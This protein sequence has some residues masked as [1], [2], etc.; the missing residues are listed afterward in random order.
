MV[1]Q[2]VERRLLMDVKTNRSGIFGETSLQLAAYRFADV[3]IDG[4]KEQ[5]M[6]A[7]D[8]C[9]GSHVRG[10]GYDLLPVIAEEMQH[11]A[12]LYVLKNSQTM[13]ELGDLVGAPVTPPQN[14]SPSEEPVV[15]RKWI[16]AH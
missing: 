6:P 7:V 8:G 1:G 9:A 4:D 14:V 11:K 2:G 3:L 5:P 10:D 12:F 15:A 13:K 16:E